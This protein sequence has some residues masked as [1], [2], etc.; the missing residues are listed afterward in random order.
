[1]DGFCLS[2]LGVLAALSVF[3]FLVYRVVHSHILITSL[4]NFF[5]CRLTA[6][7]WFHNIDLNL[8]MLSIFM[9][10]YANIK[11]IERHLPTYACRTNPAS[12][13][14]IDTR[15]ILR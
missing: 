7:I 9:P 1:M 13:Q 14:T 3:L 4:F 6:C 2:V 15:T 8:D 12:L 11:N 5:L 10:M